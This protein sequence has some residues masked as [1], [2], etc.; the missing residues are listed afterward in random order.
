MLTISTDQTDTIIDM[1]QY[2]CSLVFVIK[3][4]K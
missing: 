4:M 3:T 1:Y 2:H